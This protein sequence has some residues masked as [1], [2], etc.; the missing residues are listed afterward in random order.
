MIRA[1]ANAPWGARVLSAERKM[2]EAAASGT[3]K[4]SRDAEAAGRIYHLCSPYF[5][6]FRPFSVMGRGCLQKVLGK[7]IF[8]FPYGHTFFTNQPYDNGI[9]EIRRGKIQQGDATIWK[10]MRTTV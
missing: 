8:R 3:V 5:C 9:K 10:N 6:G 1:E 2:R 7:F 4:K